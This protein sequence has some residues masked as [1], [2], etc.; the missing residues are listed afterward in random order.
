ML[1]F[2][3]QVVHFLAAPVVCF[4]PVLDTAEHANPELDMKLPMYDDSVGVARCLPSL[5]VNLEQAIDLL[6]D[7]WHAG[8]NGLL[9]RIPPCDSPPWVNRV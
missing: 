7:W 3:T 9:T 5:A 4:P 8:L 6:S 2:D 1:V